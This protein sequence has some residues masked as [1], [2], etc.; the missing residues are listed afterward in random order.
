MET[1]LPGP[2]H[3]GPEICGDLGRTRESWLAH[4]WG[5]AS[6]L[7]AERLRGDIA[8]CCGAYEAA[9]RPLVW[10]R[11][12]KFPWRFLFRLCRAVARSQIPGDIGNDHGKCNPLGPVRRFVR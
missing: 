5:Y 4:D 9:P 11:P 7:S 10:R 12:L 1:K 3:F 2:I 6:R 8:A